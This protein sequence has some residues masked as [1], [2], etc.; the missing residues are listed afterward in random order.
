ML[1][2]HQNPPFFWHIPHLY[3]AVISTLHLFDI[4][5]VPSYINN[6]IG[7]KNN[8]KEQ[9]RLWQANCY[10]LEQAFFHLHLLFS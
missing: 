3:F 2:R 9:M 6:I 7:K 8:L 10:T 1:R 4:R 5:M